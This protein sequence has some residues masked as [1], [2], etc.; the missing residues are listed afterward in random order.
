MSAQGRDKRTEQWEIGVVVVHLF[1]ER[2]IFGDRVDAI[3]DGL[4]L[5]P[6]LCERVCSGLHEA[7]V[8]TAGFRSSYLSTSCCHR[9]ADAQNW[10]PVSSK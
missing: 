4:R 1:D 10:K 9:D 5:P 2:C 3:E 8:S 6:E 7:Q